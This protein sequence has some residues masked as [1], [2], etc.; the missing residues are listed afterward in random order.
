MHHTIVFMI[1][2]GA[3]NF[4][5]IGT[6]AITMSAGIVASSQFDRAV[7]PTGGRVD[8]ALSNT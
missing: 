1:D 6:I 5:A 7:G 3:T 8:A 4:T 2:I